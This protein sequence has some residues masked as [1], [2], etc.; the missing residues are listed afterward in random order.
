[1]SVFGGTFI[2]NTTNGGAKVKENCYR[3]TSGKVHG[4]LRVFEQLIEEKIITQRVT[5]AKLTHLMKV[6]NRL[7]RREC[8]RLLKLWK[9]SF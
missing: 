1:M 8:E 5:H 7:P 6:N 3:V 9:K 2:R 4:I